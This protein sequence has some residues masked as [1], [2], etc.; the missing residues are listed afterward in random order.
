[1]C[2]KV[3]SP[4]SIPAN[5]FVECE[6]GLFQLDGKCV[7][8]LAGTF[9]TGKN[10][11]LCEACHEN[12]FAPTV[13]T[14][15]CFAC[16]TGQESSWGAS[17]CT[18]QDTLWKTIGIPVLVTVLP[19]LFLAVI[20]YFKFRDKIQNRLLNSKTPRRET[21]SQV[22][23]TPPLQAASTS[24]SN[25]D[26]SPVS[27]APASRHDA[28]SFQMCQPS[29]HRTSLGISKNASSFEEVEAQ[30]NVQN[31]EQDQVYSSCPKAQDSNAQNHEQ[32]QAQ[33]LSPGLSSFASIQRQASQKLKTLAKQPSHK[34]Q[35]LKDQ[36]KSQADCSD[37]C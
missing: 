27:E 7:P 19:T 15:S 24:D 30:D 3:N 34:Y 28:S 20:Y 5:F 6:P 31:I 32:D 35:E 17:Q 23:G 25:E 4:E 9:S 12:S 37:K 26:P 18:D 16:P 11:R 1:M 36:N 21:R 29:T 10:V 2:P 14:T 22:Q 33:Y 8:C 13:G